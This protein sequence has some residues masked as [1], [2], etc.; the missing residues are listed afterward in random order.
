[1]KEFKDKYLW[2]GILGI[3]VA[4]FLWYLTS[5]Q[6]SSQTPQQTTLQVPYLV[7][8]TGASPTASTSLSTQPNIVGSSTNST[9]PNGTNPLSSATSVGEAPNTYGFMPQLL[10]QSTS[11]PNNSV[12]WGS[13]G[14]AYQ[15]NPYGASAV[16][17]NNVVPTA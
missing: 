4:I 8:T 5:K 7:P 9:I 11:G 3:G 6:I 10:T 14:P 12:A 13:F 15:G 1:M 16:S 2:W 17:A